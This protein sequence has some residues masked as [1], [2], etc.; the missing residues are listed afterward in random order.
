MV[1]VWRKWILRLLTTQTRRLA[2]EPYTWNKVRC[3]IYISSTRRLM[4]K[5]NFVLWVS[6]RKMWLQSRKIL[7]QEWRLWVSGYRMNTFLNVREDTKLLILSTS[8]LL[9]RRWRIIFLLPL[10]TEQETSRKMWTKILMQWVSWLVHLLVLLLLVGWMWFLLILRMLMPLRL[11]STICRKWRS[12]RLCCH[13]DKTSILCCLTLISETKYRIWVPWLMV[14][15][16][17]CGMSLSRPHRLLLAHTSQRWML[18]WWIAGLLLLW[19]VSLLLRFLVAC[20]LQSSRVSQQR[21]SF[22]SVTLHDSWRMELTLTAHG[23]GRWRIFLISES[24]LRKWPMAMWNWGSILM[25][26]RSITIGLRLF[27]N[28]VWLQ[29]CLW[30]E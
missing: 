7:T 4:E 1:R 29:I 17:P 26:W 12:G 6:Q 9:W 5:W 8:V 23:S 27:L 2:S 30:M 10:T 22:L 19:V 28:G 20:G 21:C 14:V 24:V 13:S 15:A 25:N 3:Y 11:P 16:R 18:V